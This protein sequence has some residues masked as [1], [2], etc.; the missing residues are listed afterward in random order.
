[1]KPR[2]AFAVIMCKFLFGQKRMAILFSICHL[3]IKY[4][5]NAHAINYSF[6]VDERL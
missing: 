3:K 5:L 2:F 6:L 4:I 1:M